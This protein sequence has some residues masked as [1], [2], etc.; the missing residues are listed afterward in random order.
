MDKSP[1]TQGN[2]KQD[3]HF[4]LIKDRINIS[5]KVL[6][7]IYQLFLWFFILFTILNPNTF[8][9]LIIIYF[10]YLIYEFTSNT[11]K[12][13]LNKNSTNSIYNKLKQIFCTAPVIKVSCECYHFEKHLEERKDQ[14]GNIITEEVERKHTTY[15]GLSSI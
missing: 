12:F 8:P 10:F 3:N 9:I 1:L 6:I 14:K 5:S 7:I 2:F 4:L 11:C 15:T 13:L